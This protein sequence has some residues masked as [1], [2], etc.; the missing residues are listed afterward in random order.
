MLK[1]EKK[2]KFN[3]LESVSALFL[4]ATVESF[5]STHFVLTCRNE[6]KVQNYAYEK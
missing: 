6:C 5:V 4:V 2:K 3:F 1:V